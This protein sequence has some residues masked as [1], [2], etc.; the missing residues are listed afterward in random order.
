[1][2]DNLPP[3]QSY[4]NVTQEMFEQEI[5]TRN[6]PALLKGA[7]RDWPL[8]QHAKNSPETLCAQLNM[9][10]G[11]NIKDSP[12]NPVKNIE[13]WWGHPDTKGRFFYDA[14]IKGRNF[15]KKDIR[16]HELLE[17]LLET[18]DKPDAPH[19][20]AGAVDL[21]QHI[22]QLE[23]QLIAPFLQEQYKLTSLWIGNRTRTAAHWDLPQNLACVV[24]GRRRFITFP[25]EQ[26]N[27]C[28]LYTSP[29]P[30]DRQKSR[31]PSSA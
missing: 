2:W 17:Q 30:R 5:V 8:V 18:I 26:I 3:T 13:T 1:M 9:L 4:E 31:M 10:A 14:D 29:S 12:K 20:F 28:L 21:S 7:V 24:A 11:K 22:P 23:A 25:T 19:I 15:T 16:L 6:R 27:N